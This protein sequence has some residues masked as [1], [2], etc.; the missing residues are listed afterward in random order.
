MEDQGRVTA[1]I[2]YEKP[3][4][5]DLGTAAAIQGAANCGAGSIAETNCLQGNRVGFPAQCLN[6]I[7]VGT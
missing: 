3:E 2:R 1:S 4:I 7:G 6:G 5:I